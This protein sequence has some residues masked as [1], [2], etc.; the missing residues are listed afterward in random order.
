MNVS[1]NQYGLFKT[2]K[3]LGQPR[4]KRVR[5]TCKTCK[6]VFF[7]K[8]SRKE[9][10]Y[11]SLKCR[12]IWNKGLTKKDPRVLQYITKVAQAHKG[13]R[14]SE[15][16]E[17][18]IND[19]RISGKNHWNW[20][21]GVNK[22]NRS[23]RNYFYSLGVTKKWIKEVLKR[24]DYTCQECSVR[25]GRLEA[26]HIKPWALYPELRFDINNGQTLCRNCH[27]SKSKQEMKL[28]WKNQYGQA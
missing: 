12:P 18:K 20:K 22:I 16:T 25:G 8:P 2:K 4:K 13:K 28:H 23:E 6:I 1:R 9:S 26:D 11:C 27:I 15:K 3:T 5:I 21:G 10:N 17:F 24:D 14:V 19:Y 7:V